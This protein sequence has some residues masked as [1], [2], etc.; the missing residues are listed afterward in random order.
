[1]ARTCYA[2]QPGQVQGLNSEM[3]KEFFYKSPVG[4]IRLSLSAVGLKGVSL[5]RG[6]SAGNVVR[7]EQ[8]AYAEKCIGW[9][10]AYFSGAEPEVARPSFDWS[11]ATPFQKEVWSGLMKVPFGRVVSY[12]ALAA[13]VGRPRG[14]RAVAGAMARNPIP[15]FVPCHRVVRSNGGLGGFGAGISWKLS[16]LRHE[17]LMIRKKPRGGFSVESSLRR[18]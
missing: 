14:A 7:D 5:L 10:D 12:G 18:P 15:L 2:A 17:G 9:L 11:E 1:M 4:M 16:L 6:S 8:S 13:A 3:V